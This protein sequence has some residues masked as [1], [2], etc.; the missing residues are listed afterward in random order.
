MNGTVVIQHF[1]IVWMFG[2]NVPVCQL[3]DVDGNRILTENPLSVVLEYCKTND[4]TIHNSQDIL[5]VMVLE[6]AFGT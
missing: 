1:R 5:N 6:C 4:Y 2:R 3:F